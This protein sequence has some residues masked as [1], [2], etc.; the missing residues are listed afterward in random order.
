MPYH[1]LPFT[2]NSPT[3]FFSWQCIEL[4]TMCTCAN[5]IV[6]HYI[7]LISVTTYVHAW[8]SLCHS[9][10]PV[11]YEWGYAVVYSYLLCTLCNRLGTH[12][13]PLSTHS[14]VRLVGTFKPDA[15]EANMKC[16]CQLSECPI[17]TYLLNHSGS[18]AG[19]IRWHK[20]AAMRSL[21]PLLELCLSC[22]LYNLRP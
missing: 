7:I 20:V 14:R 6:I 2:F 1:G 16:L 13:P 11:S 4:L 19:K 15:T 9:K 18:L 5:C 8:L 3:Y 22:P 10:C 12:G 17:S 21:E